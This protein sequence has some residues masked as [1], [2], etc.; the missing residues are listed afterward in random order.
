MGHKSI[1]FS[2]LF[3]LGMTVCGDLI[4][5]VK[6]THCSGHR[7]QMRNLVYQ[8]EPPNSGPARS[9]IYS[10]THRAVFWKFPKYIVL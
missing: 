9:V 4:A 2:V 7:D 1:S 8:K 10:N 5:L 6:D 3:F